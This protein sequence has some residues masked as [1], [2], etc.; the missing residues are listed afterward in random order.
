[1]DPAPEISNETEEWRPQ[2]KAARS[3][4]GKGARTLL[5]IAL[6]AAVVVGGLF[7]AQKYLPGSRPAETGTLTVD[8]NPQGAIVMVDGEQRGQ[9]PVSLSLT[10]GAHNVI[11]RGDG[12]PRTIP[13][14]IVAGATSS[15]YLDLPKAAATTGVLQVASD[16]SGARVIV[17]G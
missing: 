13:I 16:P 10:P 2:T 12:E 9:T 1:Q 8:T 5:V 17:D 3:G 11:V 14:N 7:A 15:Q 6:A 4:R